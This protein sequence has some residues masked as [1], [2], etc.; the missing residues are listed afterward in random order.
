MA[1]NNKYI[2]VEPYS[3]EWF[4]LMLHGNANYAVLAAEYMKLTG[5][6]SCC[7]ACGDVDKVAD[8]VDGQWEAIPPIRLCDDCKLLQEKLYHYKLT[9]LRRIN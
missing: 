2:N 5:T 1:T 8:Y 9:L 7:N 6:K 3:N 4:I